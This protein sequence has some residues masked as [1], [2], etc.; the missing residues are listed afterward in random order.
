MLVVTLKTWLN[1]GR[2]ATGNPSAGWHS[3]KLRK[4]LR[5]ITLYL[6]KNTICVHYKYKPLN[7]FREI[8]GID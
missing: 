2:R 8:I 5:D 3:Q 6:T 1:C 7:L 4:N